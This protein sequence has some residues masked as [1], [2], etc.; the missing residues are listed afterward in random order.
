MVEKLLLGGGNKTCRA[1]HLP[2]SP[3]AKNMAR[4]EPWDFPLMRVLAVIQRFGRYVK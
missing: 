2:A 4:A 3:A 1:K